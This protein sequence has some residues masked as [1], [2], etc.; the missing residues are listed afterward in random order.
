MLEQTEINP[1]SIMRP[2]I[3]AGDQRA[4]NHLETCTQTGGRLAA[5][6]DRESS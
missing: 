5:V 1:G 3:K 6:D 4:A 2:M